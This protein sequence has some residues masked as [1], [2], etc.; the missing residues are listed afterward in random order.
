MSEE[1]QAI[2]GPIL[3]IEDNW[4][5]L[6]LMNHVLDDLDLKGRVIAVHNG[7]AALER[8]LDVENGKIEKPTAII[9]DL[10]LPDMPG[11]LLIAQIR[12]MTSLEDTPVAIFSDAPLEKSEPILEKYRLQACHQ[13]P[14]DFA[15]FQKVFAGILQRWIGGEKSKSADS[16]A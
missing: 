10:G 15:E 11:E 13:K 2:S 1:L 9:V 7:A 8:I 5:D 4:H 14:S 12:R 6:V 3:V 16:V